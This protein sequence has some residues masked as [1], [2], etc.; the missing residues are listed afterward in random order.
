MWPEYGYSVAV[1]VDGMFAAVQLSLAALQHVSKCLELVP[2]GNLTLNSDSAAAAAAV[3]AAA[4][5]A[6]PPKVI[7]QLLTL[8]FG[9]AGNDL[10]YLANQDEL[11][12]GSGSAAAVGWLPSATHCMSIVL[13]V[14]AY[15]S[16]VQTEAPGVRDKRGN[17]TAGKQQ[18]QQQQAKRL[19]ARAAPA[20]ADQVKSQYPK[21]VGACVWLAAA[22]T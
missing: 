15:T 7:G 13:I 3:A 4:G 8:A 17:K 10:L 14:A 5:G 18:R 11:C 16:W 12:E 2:T 21:G 6:M 20:W 19:Q 9:N 22:H 1:G